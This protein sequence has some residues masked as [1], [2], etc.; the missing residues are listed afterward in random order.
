[1]K[2]GREHARREEDDLVTV[3]QLVGEILLN[4]GHGAHFLIDERKATL[5]GTHEQIFQQVRKRAARG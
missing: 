3:L 4:I 1:M 2:V 5:T